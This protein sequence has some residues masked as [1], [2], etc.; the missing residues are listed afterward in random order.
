[1]DDLLAQWRA[2]EATQM[3]GWDFSALRGRY[4]EDDPPWDFQALCRV[5]LRSARSVLDMGT[6]G[7]ERLLDLAADLPDDTTATEGWEPNVPVAT[8]ALAPHG[9]PVLRHDPSAYERLPFAAGRF[10]LIMNRHESCSFPEVA[11]TL[12]PGGAFLTQQ[13]GADNLT[14][15]RALFGSGTSWPEQT[16]THWS[17]GLSA[18]GLTVAAGDEWRGESRFTSVTALI[19]Y[20]RLV[21][22]EVPDD[23]GVDRYLPVLQGLYEEF[24]ARGRPITFTS[25]RFWLRADAPPGNPVE[26]DP[27]GRVQ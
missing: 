26:E 4:E 12:G 15:A 11:R 24:E 27:G 20:L 3:T 10:D 7:G 2:A 21:P 16:L 8:A 5:A 22:W 13:I 19:H 1:M 18:A 14:Q 25:H 23:F 17:A 6:G 9:I